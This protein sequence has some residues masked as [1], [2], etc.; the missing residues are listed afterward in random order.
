MSERAEQEAPLLP[1]IEV[2][3]ERVDWHELH[4]LVTAAYASMHGRIDPPSSLLTMTPAEFER[5]A[6]DEHLIVASVDG[7]LVGCVFCGP[8]EDW[9]YIGKLAVAP[10]LQRSGVGRRLIDAARRFAEQAGLDGLELDT[11]IELTENH[12][13]FD[14]LGFVKVAE[15]SH[16]GYARVTSIRMR[17]PR[18]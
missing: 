14:R 2:D 17:S 12:R 18:G 5:K 11:R 13:A 4:R 10:A 9:L 16:P 1:R 8:Q 3:P 6:A 15:L 7:R